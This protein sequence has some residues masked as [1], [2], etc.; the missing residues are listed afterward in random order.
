LPY[1][2]NLLLA[3]AAT[4]GLAWIIRSVVDWLIAPGVLSTVAG[5]ALFML[6]YGAACWKRLRATLM[7]NGAQP[8]AGHV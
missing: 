5:I 1:D 3:A 8:V 4:L 2:L 6:L 7:G